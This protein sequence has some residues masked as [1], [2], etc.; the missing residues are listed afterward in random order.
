MASA[1]QVSDCV[2]RGLAEARDEPEAL[3]RG[4]IRGGDLVIDS[5][6]AEC[7]IVFVEDELG[8][9]ELVSSADLEPEQMTS[10]RTL[11]QMLVRRAA[12]AA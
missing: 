4:Q 3:V 5:K 9:G 12:Q 7:V 11:T 10:L 6:E 8:L 1:S 2:I